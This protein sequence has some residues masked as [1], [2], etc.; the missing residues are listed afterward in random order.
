ML[1]ILFPFWTKHLFFTE[2]L[3][4]DADV[5]QAS[6][7]HRSCWFIPLLKNHETF[8]SS[9]WF[10]FRT[11]S[12][13]SHTGHGKR[14]NLNQDDLR[15]LGRMI[16]SW[17]M[18][19]HLLIVSFF[20]LRIVLFCR[21]NDMFTFPKTLWETGD[22]F[23]PRSRKKSR[24]IFLHPVVPLGH[25]GLHHLPQSSLKFLGDTVGTSQNGCLSNWKVAHN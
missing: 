16:M 5:T 11:H 23:S 14:G 10:N 18:P 22:F 7:Q 2:R 17:I 20:T 4:R 1:V 9:E 8:F 12:Y 25:R 15:N 6:E 21:I 24:K 13:N 3:N 19:G